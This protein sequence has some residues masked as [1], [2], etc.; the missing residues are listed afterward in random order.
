MIDGKLS[1]NI[2]RIYA[3]LMMT[4]ATKIASG[5][6][7][8]V[9][10]PFPKYPEPEI[11]NHGRSSRCFA[12]S[13][14]TWVDSSAKA[15]ELLRDGAFDRGASFI[16]RNTAQ[17]KDN[18]KL[19]QLPSGL[20][21][22]PPEAPANAP[23][24]PKLPSTPKTKED[25]LRMY[26]S[27]EGLRKA[28]AEYRR[29][30]EAFYRPKVEL[31]QSEQD[32]VVLSVNLD[33]PAFVILEDAFYPGWKVS[34]DAIPTT[35]YRANGVD[36]AV[37]VDKGAHLVQFDFKPDSYTL[38]LKCFVMGLAVFFY[39]AIWSIARLIIQTIRFMSYG[40]WEQ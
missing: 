23:S 13:N 27:V 2:N 37:Y 34:I 10:N 12:T 25:L 30:I 21:N 24:K 20:L 40:V 7:F 17:S 19:Q 9:M 18:E 36:R 32:H 11:Q 1:K 39:L 15:A 16:E 5:D 31:T 33:D 26:G 14:W 35:C 38:G 28:F 4:G 22:P 3:L 29:A 8:D 6:H